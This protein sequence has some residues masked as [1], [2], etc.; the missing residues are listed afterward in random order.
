MCFKRKRPKKES[1]KDVKDV[2]LLNRYLVYEKIEQL[3]EFLPVSQNLL[4]KSCRPGL[5]VNRRGALVIEP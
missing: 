2:E 5:R 3:Y 4:Q 1:R